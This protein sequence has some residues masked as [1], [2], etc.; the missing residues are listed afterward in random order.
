MYGITETTVHVTYRELTAA[1]ARG[2][3][4][5]RIGV[6][7]PDLQVYV[8]DRHQE[9]VPEG[10]AG[11]LCVGGAGLAWGYLG[12][13]EL[14]A[15]RF[16]P[17]PF[18][19]NTGERLYRSGDLARWISGD[20]EYLGRIDHQVKVRGFRIELGEIESALGRHEAV[21]EAVVLAR[22]D[23]GEARLVAY[24]VFAPGRSATAGELRGFVGESLPEYM[25]PS[26]FMILPALPLTPNGKVD[27]KAL[28]APAEDRSAAGERY[29]APRNE[30]ELMLVGIWEDLLGIRPIGVLDDFFA[31]GGHSMLA[32]R[33]VTRIRARLGCD[34]SPVDLFQAPTVER[35]AAFLRRQA[36]AERGVL[37]GIQP[38]GPQRPLFCVHPAGG[39][40]LCFAAL[41]H[42]LGPDQ[43]FYALQSIDPELNRIE[44]MAAC[45]LDAVRKV[46][47]EGPYLLAGWSLGGLIAFEM[48]RALR[49][50]GQEVD[51]LALFDVS[52]PL[53]RLDEEIDVHEQ[54]ASLAYNIWSTAGQETP[55]TADD[56]RGSTVEEAMR[57]IY[58][59]AAEDRTIPPDIDFSDMLGFFRMFTAHLQARRAYVA[60]PYAGRVTLIRA[61]EQPVPVDDETL[62]WREIAAGGV[63]VYES[64]GH[65][66]N[67]VRPP[68][69]AGLAQRLRQI[70]EELEK[71]VAEEEE[72]QE[73]LQHTTTF[74]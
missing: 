52:A 11:E 60:K 17:H 72:P 14:T 10:V 73:A 28:P 54:A 49:A 64:P 43:P 68:Q 44:E 29:I 65:H 15:E 30:L 57:R 13:P 23:S 47:P 59:K 19:A 70:L 40:V 31:L 42:G 22:G 55:L 41:A 51:L 34:L 58:E 12:R 63:A 61:A 2:G 1:D 9:L 46:Q 66:Y 3:T 37:V 62:G 39:D 18:A 16:V 48:A 27:R 32:I 8:L 6:A 74:V 4:G 56:L 67:M 5:S 38:A 25:V 53:T 20:L 26:A 24:V 21:R 69:A 50:E 35:L 36:P 7:I 71:G 45:Y 33:L